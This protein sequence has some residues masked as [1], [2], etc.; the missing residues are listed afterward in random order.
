MKVDADCNNVKACFPVAV[1]YC[2]VEGMTSGGF[3]DNFWMQMCIREMS[4]ARYISILSP[5][6]W[7][8]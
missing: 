4:V 3:S 7:H 2:D 6:P 1:I 8:P 5:P